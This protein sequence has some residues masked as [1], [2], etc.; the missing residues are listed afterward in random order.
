[1]KVNVPVPQ[2]Y[3]V[4]SHSLSSKNP[5]QFKRFTNISLTQNSQFL[6]ASSF[7]RSSI[8]DSFI[9][10]PTESDC[11][12]NDSEAKQVEEIEKRMNSKWIKHSN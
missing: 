3:C 11:Y 5:Q 2:I 10:R 7:L 6:E 4:T 9:I 8:N 1:M 12:A